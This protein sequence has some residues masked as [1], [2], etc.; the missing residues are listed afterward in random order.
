MDLTGFD[1][2]VGGMPTAAVGTLA[3]I[4]SPS[5]LNDQVKVPALRVTVNIFI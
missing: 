3:L 1:P 4:A 5:R 2:Q